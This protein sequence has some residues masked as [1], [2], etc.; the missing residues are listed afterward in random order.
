MPRVF[1]HNRHDILSLVALAGWVAETVAQ[2]PG[3]DL[4]PDELAGLGRLLEAAEPDRG[5]A[6]YRMALDRGLASPARERLLGRLAWREKRRSRWDAS[7]VLWEAAARGARIF[8]S[9]PWEEMAKI[10]EHRLRDLAAAHAVVTEALDRAHA[11]RAPAPVVEA[12]S[13]RL[14][15]LSRRLERGRLT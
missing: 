10:H 11:H 3:V 7:R 9:R 8:D 13:H 12:L 15:R 1:E 2:A 14:A 5:E 6:C 4:G